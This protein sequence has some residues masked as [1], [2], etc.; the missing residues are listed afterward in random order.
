VAIDLGPSGA[1]RNLFTQSLSQGLK[2]VA[3]DLGPSGADRD[4]SSIPHVLLFEGDVVFPQK[5]AELILE[6]HGSVM[7]RLY[8]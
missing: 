7:F 3:I 4:L 8:G 1:G 5:R 6:C 2:P